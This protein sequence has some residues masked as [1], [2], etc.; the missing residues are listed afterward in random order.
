M[1]LRT[2]KPSSDCGNST[3]F[4]LSN[5]KQLLLLTAFLWIFISA[6]AQN[7][8]KADQEEE[9]IFCNI[10]NYFPPEFPGGHA[11][12]TAFISRNFIDRDSFSDSLPVPFRGTVRIEFGIEKS[13]K[14]CCFEVMTGINPLI[15]SECVRVL[16]LMPKWEPATESGR[17]I[18]A[19]HIIRI[20]Y[21]VEEDTTEQCADSVLLVSNTKE[22]VMGELQLMRLSLFSNSSRHL[23]CLKSSIAGSL[24]I[25]TRQ[26]KY[27]ANRRDGKTPV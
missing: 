2:K 16:K 9:I 12:L 19:V 13:G 22:E 20:T 15:D 6:S 11:A 7:Q 1:I 21:V 25:I 26:N 18:S 3:P 27:N 5:M 8:N 24:F 10:G 23:T 4:H 14:P 17:N